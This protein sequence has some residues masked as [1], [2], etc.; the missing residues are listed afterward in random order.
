MKAIQGSLIGLF[1]VS[2]SFIGCT[3]SPVRETPVRKP[4]KSVVIDCIEPK[5]TLNVINNNEATSHRDGYDEE[6]LHQYQV[7]YEV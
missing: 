1:L 6:V 5:Y 3:T 7:C 2:L 4:V